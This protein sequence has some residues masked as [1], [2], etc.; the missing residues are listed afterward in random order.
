MTE[1]LKRIFDWQRPRKQALMMAADCLLMAL[2]VWASF[3]L[4][5][6][7]GFSEKFY[8]FWYLHLLLPVASIPLFYLAGM[9]SAVVRYM[10][11]SDVWAVL[12]GVTLSTLFFIAVVVFGGLVAVPRTAITIYWLMALLL[13]G[14]SRFL[15]RAWHQAARHRRAS[16]EPV[17]IYGAGSAGLQLVNS[18]MSTGDYLPVA[19]VDDNPRLHGSMIRGV[20]VYAPVRLGRLIS[21]L[22]ARSILLALPSATL[23]RRREILADLERYPVHVRTLPSMTDLVSGAARLQD[24][25]EV[26][27]EDLLG[28]EAIPPDE[29]LLSRCV[30]GRSVM[31]TGAGGSIGSELCRQILAQSPRRLVLFE[32][33]EVALYRI[34]QELMALAAA[35]DDEVAI[36]PVLDSVLYQERLRQ[37]LEHY[38]VTTV[39]HAAAYKHVPLVESNPQAGIHNNLVGTWNA[40]LAAEQAGVGYFVLVSTDKAVRPASVMGV[41]KRLA[42]RAVQAIASGPSSTRFGIVRFGNVLDSS[43]S[44]IPLFRRQIREGGPVTVTHPET[45]RYFM[46]IPEAASLVLQAGGMAETAEVFVLNMGQPVRIQDLARRLIQLSGCSVRDAETPKG[47][48]AIEFIGLRD[49]EKL[50][51]RLTYTETVQQTHHPMIWMAPGHRALQR[52]VFARWMAQLES[53]LVAVDTES[54]V[55]LIGEQLPEFAAAAREDH[56]QPAVSGFSKASSDTAS[57][58]RSV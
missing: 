16:E 55:D 6:G 47:D 32:C 22:G 40:A 36:I 20:P 19:F 15:V 51:E 3:A 54:V 49:G 29:D 46:T 39:Y 53:A 17:I 56:Q 7:D 1:W 52:D 48:I 57:P 38:Q 25:R 9:Y 43:G 42:E 18:L 12:R 5:M 58:I 8:Q 4:R 10:G 33:S 11:P 50:H 45:T 34:E 24:L 23:G 13:I 14:G 27:I 37:C 21:Q 30:T 44:V 31:V 2:V 41:S 26:D 35:S 28:R